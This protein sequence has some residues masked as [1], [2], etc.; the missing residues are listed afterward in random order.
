MYNIIQLPM[1]YRRN[2]I[3]VNRK[4]II[5]VL[6]LLA[7]ACILI[8]DIKAQTLYD[9]PT[10][11]VPVR[12]KAQIFSA[13]TWEQA[14]KGVPDIKIINK[15]EEE[16]EYSGE[17]ENL[18]DLKFWQESPSRIIYH[19][20]KY[21]TWIM[22]IEW[23]AD[24]YNAD[25]AYDY[26]A[27]K[28]YHLTSGDGYHWNVEGEI[29]AGEPGS[30]DDSRREG[31]QVVKWEG[32]FWMFYA[33]VSKKSSRYR[34]TFTGIGL[35]VA[36]RPEGPWKR[37]AK[38]PVLKMTSD[39]AAWDN[40]M[41]NNPYPVYFKGK[42]YI[43]YKSRNAELTGGQTLQGVAIADSITG[44]YVRYMNNPVC[45][46]HGSFVWA[47]RGGITMLA[48]GTGGKIHWSPDGIHF[49]NV[50]DPVSRGIDTPIFSAFYLPHD[51]LSGDPVSDREPDEFWGLETRRTPGRN[52]RDW[53]IFRGT[54]TFNPVVKDENK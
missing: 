3:I 46:G 27:F 15:K 52:P 41:L 28:N 37:A 54:V 26:S 18:V 14:R 50:D 9:Y 29:P 49:I 6:I 42:W 11:A 7:V 5:S 23:Y 40:D 38:G 53:K 31:L 21:H 16:I 39:P 20:G 1:Y 35:L 24:L 25:P 12:L 43:Y 10:R 13:L 30:F 36:N 48:F 4:R 51:P 8:T 17:K 45:D 22:H 32:K 47:Y 33:G 34:S 44:P 2:A 19:E